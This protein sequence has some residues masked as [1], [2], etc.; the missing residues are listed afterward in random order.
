M[1]ARAETL[2]ALVFLAG[3]AAITTGAA[4]VHPA[5]GFVIGGVVVCGTSYLIWRGGNRSAA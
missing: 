3:L 5:A 4:I 1:S 2:L